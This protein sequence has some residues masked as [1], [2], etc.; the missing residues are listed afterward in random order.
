MRGRLTLLIGTMLAGV[1]GCTDVLSPVDYFGEY[2]LTRVGGNALPAFVFDNGSVSAVVVADTIR[3]RSDGTGSRTGVWIYTNVGPQLAITAPNRVEGTS[4]FVY[5]VVK[6]R[7]EMTTVC[8][9]LANCAPPP[10]VVAIRTP[11]GLSVTFEGIARV[12][13]E[14]TALGTR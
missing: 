2:A 6:N 10:H 8:G 13:Q 12:P 4:E 11:N 5:K 14:Y 7:L 1:A 3:I 9:P